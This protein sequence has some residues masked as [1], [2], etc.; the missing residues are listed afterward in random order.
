MRAPAASPM[1]GTAPLG[2]PR[3][4]RRGPSRWPAGRGGRGAGAA[5]WAPASSGGVLASFLV[6]H[7]TCGGCLRSLTKR[8]LACVR[9]AVEMPFSSTLAAAAGATKRLR[10]LTRRASLTRHE[11][12][13]QA[14]GTSP[15]SPARHRVPCRRCACRCQPPGAPP[16]RL[17]Q[18]AAI[19][20]QHWRAAQ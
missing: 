8:V 5:G 3:S 13:L 11:R 14:T 4:P 6:R 10:S 12:C 9:V 1:E 19:F 16:A 17:R 15:A 20:A 7:V 2:A 18:V